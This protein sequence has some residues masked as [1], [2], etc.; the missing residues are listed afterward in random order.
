MRLHLSSHQVKYRKSDIFARYLVRAM[1]RV[2]YIQ[3]TGAVMMI[4]DKIRKIVFLHTRPKYHNLKE[5]CA[6]SDRYI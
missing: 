3:N 4:C 5:M 1:E 2:K 6:L